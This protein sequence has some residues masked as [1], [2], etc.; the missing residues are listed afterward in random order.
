MMCV[1]LRM[2]VTTRTQTRSCIGRTAPGRVDWPRLEWRTV[3]PVRHCHVPACAIHGE[4]LRRQGAALP[5]PEND[6]RDGVVSLVAHLTPARW[7]APLHSLPV[8]TVRH[9]IISYHVHLPDSSPCPC[10]LPGPRHLQPVQNIRISIG[11]NADQQRSTDP[12][13]ANHSINKKSALFK[14]R[15]VEQGLCAICQSRDLRFQMKEKP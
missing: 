10:F 13:I 4:H 6:A 3:Q 12:K 7:C 15:H 14:S 5:A 11:T 2:R 8:Q 1:S 9:G